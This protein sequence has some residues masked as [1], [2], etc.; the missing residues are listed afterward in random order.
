MKKL[1]SVLLLFMLAAGLS[2]QQGRPALFSLMR[3]T[4]RMMEIYSC[5]K[6][7]GVVFHC[8]RDMEFEPYEI[9]RIQT[10]SYWGNY[11]SHEKDSIAVFAAIELFQE[12]ISGNLRKIISHPDFFRRMNKRQ[13]LSDLKGINTVASD[14]GRLFNF[15]FDSKS[16]SVYQT[17]TSVMHYLK[18]A[19]NATGLS[20]WSSDNTRMEKISPSAYQVFSTDGYNNIYLLNK[21]KAIYLLTGRTP[22]RANSFEC[23]ADLVSFKDGVFV[24]DF[25]HR[26]TTNKPEDCVNFNQQ[27]KILVMGEYAFV[28]NGTTFVRK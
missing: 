2:A 15:T 25:E 7:G 16:G 23:Y 27:H 17:Q 8:F 6:P 19:Y 9:D 3:E 14:D 20:S 11:L 4:N 1:F 5:F 13:T 21:E 18:P 26:I 12:R 28:F 22:A 24:K 10:D